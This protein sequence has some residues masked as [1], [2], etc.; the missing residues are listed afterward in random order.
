MSLDLKESMEGAVLMGRGMLFHSLG[1]ATAKARSPLSLSLD[2][3]IVSSPKSADL[4]DLEIEWWVRR[5]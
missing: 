2:C 4:R 3:G 5:G 1:A